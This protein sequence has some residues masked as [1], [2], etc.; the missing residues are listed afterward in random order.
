MVSDLKSHAVSPPH[1]GGTGQPPI[2]DFKVRLILWSSIILAVFKL[3]FIY[4]RFLQFF[5]ESQQLEKT[6]W[7]AAYHLST[8]LVMLIC[9]TAASIILLR[10]FYAYLKLGF[11]AA[12]MMLHSLLLCEI[13]LINIF[14]TAESGSEKKGILLVI[15]LTFLLRIGYIVLYSYALRRI[16]ILKL[17]PR[18]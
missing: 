17:D 14:F 10:R 13:N 16:S 6:D 7:F 1:P 8:D 5:K 3:D 2:A 4:N 9:I 18:R 15:T 12:V 11:I